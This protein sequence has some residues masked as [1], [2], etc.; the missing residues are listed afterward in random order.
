M[1]LK[2]RRITKFGLEKT[3]LGRKLPVNPGLLIVFYTHYSLTL[4]ELWP[5]C[6]FL[7]T[8]LSLVSTTLNKFY[9]LLLNTIWRRVHEPRSEASPRQRPSP[10]LSRGAFYLKTQGF[11]TLPHPAYS[12]DLAPCDFWLNPVIKKCLSGRKFETHTAVGRALFQCTDSIPK[13]D[14]K[15][16]LKNWIKRMKKFVEVSRI[17]KGECSGH[18]APQVSGLSKRPS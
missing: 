9:L 16:A 5:E 3:G 12:P 4:E 7:N 10:L 11:K 14:Y 13:C 8:R 2:G 1:N 15:S 18:N 17:W 6:Q